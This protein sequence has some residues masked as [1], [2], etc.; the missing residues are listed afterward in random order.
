MSKS[1]LN[2]R[3]LVKK[4]TLENAIVVTFP[5]IFIFHQLAQY[6][7][8]LLKL[9]KMRKLPTWRPNLKGGQKGLA[10]KHEMIQRSKVK[11][12]YGKVLK[13]EQN[14]FSLVSANIKQ[15]RLGRLVFERETS[16]GG[17]ACTS[18]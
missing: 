4:A 15:R 13:K 6:C 17:T 16:D 5:I 11:K 1:L 3:K 2:L 7:S 12:E 18:E 14:S 10:R 8:F 9:L